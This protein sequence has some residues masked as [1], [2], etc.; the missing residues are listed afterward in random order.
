MAL[1]YAAIQGMRCKRARSKERPEA[2]N[3]LFGEDVYHGSMYGLFT[4]AP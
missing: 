3:L 1:V 2:F 4:P